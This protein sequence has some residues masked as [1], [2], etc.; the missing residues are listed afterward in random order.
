MNIIEKD[1]N[2][3]DPGIAFAMDQA[4]KNSYM[5]FNG[6]EVEQLTVDH[7]IVSMKL[8][9]EQKNPHGTAHG[10]VLYTIADTVAGLLSR[11]D[12][13][14]YMTL[15][16]E[17][18]YL[19]AASSGKI[20]GEGIIVRRGRTTVV[21]DVS[22]KDEVGKELCRTTITMFCIGRPQG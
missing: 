20:Y 19:R 1:I 2:M 10:G 12:G 9:D 5:I 6:I 7:C 17:I 3:E 15:D 14:Q 22:I 11:A 13:R 8:R 21:M 4:A 16:G 18:H